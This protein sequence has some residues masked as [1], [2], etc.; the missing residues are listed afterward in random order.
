MITG[1]F[2]RS[3]SGHG[4]Y[5]QHRAPSFRELH[6]QLLDVHSQAGGKKIPFLSIN[7]FACYLGLSATFGRSTS[8]KSVNKGLD[9]PAIGISGGMV[10]RYGTS[11]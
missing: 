9:Q 11:G 6:Q 3:T 5:D 2:S 10:D 7:N 1:G 4:F 8:E